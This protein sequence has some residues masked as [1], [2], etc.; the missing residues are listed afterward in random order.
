M[1][2]ETGRGVGSKW[3]ERWKGISQTN[4]LKPIMGDRPVQKKEQPTTLALP[5]MCA[6]RT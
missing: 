5:R 4:H 3:G 6:R 2:K 1:R